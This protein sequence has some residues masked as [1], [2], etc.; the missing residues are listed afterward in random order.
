MNWQH[1]M[2]TKQQAHLRTKFRMKMQ[3]GWSNRFCWFQCGWKTINA[4]YHRLFLFLSNGQIL[5]ICIK[6][7]FIDIKSDFFPS[8][9]WVRILRLIFFFGRWDNLRLYLK[10]PS[11]VRGFQPVLFLFPSLF[12]WPDTTQAKKVFSNNFF[13]YSF[14]KIVRIIIDICNKQQTNE[15]ISIAFTSSESVVCNQFQRNDFMILNMFT[16]REKKNRFRSQISWHLV[17]PYKRSI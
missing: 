3:Y 11:I 15:Q 2:L 17:K 4:I 9:T 7:K 10:K 1:R 8:N 13:L 5:Q 14:N 12:H 6:I 16:P